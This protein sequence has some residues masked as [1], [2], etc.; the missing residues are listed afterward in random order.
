MKTQDKILFIVI[1]LVI[2]VPIIINYYFLRK[3]ISLIKDVEKIV[4][5]LEKTDMPENT[6]EILIDNGYTLDNK[7]Y[8]VKGQGVIFLESEYSVMLS[9]D[10]MCALKL[11]YD[12]K[13]MFQKYVCPKYRLVDGE[14]IKIDE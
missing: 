13:V 7:E 1:L 10:G 6:I 4:S 8:K 9:R 12:E 3:K 11:P 2:I 14:I 5:I